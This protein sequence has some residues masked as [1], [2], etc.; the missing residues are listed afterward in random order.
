M[1]R[2]RRLPPVRRAVLAALSRAARGALAALV[3]AGAPAAAQ[4][5]GG[6]PSEVTLAVSFGPEIVST[7]GD[8]AARLGMVCAVTEYPSRS[9]PRFTLREPYLVA[10]IDADAEAFV[11]YGARETRRLHAAF[12]H[13]GA[14]MRWS[15]QEMSR[16]SGGT[17]GE[18]DVDAV[19]DL[20]RSGETARRWRTEA[21]ILFADELRAAPG[22]HVSFANPYQTGRSVAFDFGGEAFPAW[23]E[24]AHDLM[25][26]CGLRGD[27]RSVSQSRLPRTCERQAQTT[28]RF[29]VDYQSRRIQ[30][31]VD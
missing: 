17:D 30:E 5:A 3:V 28:L 25:R 26:C 31:P 21:T 29:R 19:L 16:L 20:R 13:D 22:L 27:G 11:F 23:A 2:C 6:L 1:T 4:T 9:D 24:A 8:G 10:E 18:L 14:L 7:S 12:E 15:P